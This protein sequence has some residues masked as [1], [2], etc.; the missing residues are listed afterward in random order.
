MFGPWWLLVVVLVERVLAAV[1]PDLVHPSAHHLLLELVDRTLGVG[2]GV[3]LMAL[4]V[5]AR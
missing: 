1:I 3:G 2:F 4:V 5:C